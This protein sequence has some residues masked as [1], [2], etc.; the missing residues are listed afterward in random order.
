MLRGGGGGTKKDRIDTQNC[1]TVTIP[2]YEVA[3]T[4]LN[5]DSLSLS[6]KQK[7]MS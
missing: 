2:N 5:N 4:D 7:K 6:F 1:I 3:K